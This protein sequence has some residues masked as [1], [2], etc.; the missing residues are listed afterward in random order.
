MKGKGK[1]IIDLSLISFPTTNSKEL[2]R[3][4]KV[5]NEI[6]YYSKINFII[7]QNIKGIKLK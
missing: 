4:E 7:I 1:Q 3:K 2:E 6:F 5:F